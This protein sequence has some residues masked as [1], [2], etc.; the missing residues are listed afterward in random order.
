MSAYHVSDTVLNAFHEL[1]E[2]ELAEL[3]IQTTPTSI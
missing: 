2:D 3:E 1:F